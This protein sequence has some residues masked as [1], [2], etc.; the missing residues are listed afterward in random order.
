MEWLRKN[1]FEA[2]CW[3]VGGAFLGLILA[4]IVLVAIGRAS[5]TTG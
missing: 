2:C 5:V 4:L 1:W 3:A